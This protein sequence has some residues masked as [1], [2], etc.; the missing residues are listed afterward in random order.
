MASAAALRVA[1]ARALASPP[2][3]AQAGAATITDDA[4]VKKRVA[5]VDVDYAGSAAAA[6]RRSGLGR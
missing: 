2:S 5:V 3:K 1:A 6:V 4:G